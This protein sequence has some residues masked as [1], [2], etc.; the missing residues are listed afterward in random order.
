MQIGAIMIALGA[1][2]NN[3][4][5]WRERL[6]A[7]AIA[8]G[9]AN[10]EWSVAGVWCVGAMVQLEPNMARQRQR[11]EQTEW[12]IKSEFTNSFFGNP[13]STPTGKK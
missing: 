7:F 9:N 13:L 4:D 11:E 6:N 5:T 2:R 1:K 8:T 12:V 3:L 10:C